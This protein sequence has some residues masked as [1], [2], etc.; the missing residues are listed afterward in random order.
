MEISTSLLDEVQYIAYG[1]S[2]QR[3]Q[4]GKVTSVK[5]KDI[6]KQPVNNP[7]LALQGRVPGLLITQANGLPGGGVKVRIQGQN[8]L[9]NGNDPLYVIDGVPFLS[10]L[11]STNLD[12]VLGSSGG[13]ELFQLL[14]IR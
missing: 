6:E 14:V 4:T 11:P 7:L 8:S 3:F 12:G 10:Q 1:T 5:A 2:S 9:R 13:M